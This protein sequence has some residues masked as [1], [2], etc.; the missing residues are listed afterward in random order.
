MMVTPFSSMAAMTVLF[1]VS[2]LVWGFFEIA[3]SCANTH[4]QNWG[5]YLAGGILDLLIGVMLMSSNIFEQMEILAF[6]MGFWLLFRGA[7]LM[8]HSFEFKHLGVKNWGWLLVLSIVM[9]LAEV[10]E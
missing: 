10:N 1:S 6:F 2:F 8:G 7:S 3:F 5:W 9:L 4:A